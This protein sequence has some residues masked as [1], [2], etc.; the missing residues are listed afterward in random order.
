M[1]SFFETTLRGRLTVRQYIWVRRS[2]SY[3]YFAIH[4]GV[5]D[6][7]QRLGIVDDVEQKRQNETE[8]V[9]KSL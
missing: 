6:C 3:H 2:A 1:A 8:G 4:H 5:F 9:E 7:L